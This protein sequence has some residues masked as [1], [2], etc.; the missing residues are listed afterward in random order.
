MIL[1]NISQYCAK[2]IASNKMVRIIEKLSVDGTSETQ[3]SA[4]GKKSSCPG[5][6]LRHPTEFAINVEERSRTNCAL[7]SAS[8]VVDFRTS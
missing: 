8:P 6:L 3:L 5:V 2:G 4:F 1:E 7:I